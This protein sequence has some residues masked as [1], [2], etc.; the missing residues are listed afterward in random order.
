MDVPTLKDMDLKDKKV[1][2][3]EIVTMFI[4]TP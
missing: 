1:I 3:R 4:I 2:V